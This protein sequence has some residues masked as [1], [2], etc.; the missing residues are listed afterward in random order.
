MSTE[1][2]ETAP[3]AT[4][5]GD[6]DQPTVPIRR[7]ASARSEEATR[8]LDTGATAPGSDEP[9]DG[10]SPTDRPR[11]PESGG[12]PTTTPVLTVADASAGVDQPA[13]T[14]PHEAVSSS[15]ATALPADDRGQRPSLRVGTV[16]WGLV[17]AIIGAGI[18]AIAAGAQFDLELAF[19][20]LLALAGV[21]LVAGSVAA[22][23]RRRH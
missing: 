9:S 4:G 12:A 18:V 23:V 20:A 13:D 3:I 8:A 21:G 22:G 6:G 11:P 2:N 19:I 1:N 7:P 16:V 17:I 14:A 10:A 5:R 15:G